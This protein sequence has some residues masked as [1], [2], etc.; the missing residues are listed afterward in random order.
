MTALLELYNPECSIRV[1][2]LILKVTREN[3]VCIPHAL[4]YM[5]LWECY[6]H[7]NKVWYWHSTVLNITSHFYSVKVLAVMFSFPFL[8]H[9]PTRDLQRRLGLLKQGVK[10][11]YTLSQIDSY[12]AIINIMNITESVVS[13][14]LSCELIHLAW[15]TIRI[16]ISIQ[17][18]YS[19][20]IATKHALYQ[21]FSGT[22]DNC[23]PHTFAY[24]IPSNSFLL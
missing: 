13:N 23:R 9:F 7:P 5:A 24:M 4:C 3:K 2:W 10:T 11:S 18:T 22:M 15:P 16:L 17:P 21:H 8:V 14:V 1:Y 6:N 20:Y 19:S 12:I